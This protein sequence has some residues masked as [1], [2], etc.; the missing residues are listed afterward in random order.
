MVKRI[1]SVSVGQEYI[2]AL[3]LRAV[4]RKSDFE[5]QY[6][7]LIKTSDA[8]TVE[9]L[10]DMIDYRA[11]HDYTIEDDNQ[12]YKLKNTSLE[13]SI[14]LTGMYDY[15]ILV[16]ACNWIDRHK[17]CFGKT[18]LDVGCDCGII[19]CFIAKILPDSHIFSIDRCAEAVNNAKQLAEKQDISNI[20]FIHTDLASMENI[21][22]D[23]V[24]SMRTLCMNEG[25]GQWSE[26]EDS[27]V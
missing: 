7:K 1:K 13:L 2:S 20:E 11:D 17:E 8:E 15:D 9:R 23:T 14:A 12:F 10:F 25:Y 21:Q 5:K 19:S 3:G 4:R 26:C 18:I 22:F 27:S 16:E 24:F 6:K